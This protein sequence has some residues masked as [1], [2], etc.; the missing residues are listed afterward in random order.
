MQSAG[1]ILAGG[2]GTR[3]WPLSTEEKPKQFLELFGGESL[4][5]KSWGRLSR[6][7]SPETIFV[8]TQ[9]G[10]RQR[11][12]EQLPRLL[13]ENVLTEPSRRNTAPAIALA[14]ARINQKLPGATVAIVPSD[15]A[16]TNETS[17]SKA[18]STALRYAAGHKELV[19]IGIEPAEP[20]SGFGY[21][22]LGTAVDEDIYRV[23][24]YVEKPPREKA[25]AFVR[26]GNYLWN[27]GM[28]V[29]SLAAFQETLS[30]VAPAIL[31]L[32]TR[33]LDGGNEKELY[34]RMPLISIDFAVMEKAGS[35]VTVRAQNLG[36]SDVGTWSSVVRLTTSSSKGSLTLENAPGVL[37]IGESSRPVVVIGVENIAIVDSPHGLLVL[38]LDHS[39]ELSPVVKK[40]LRDKGNQ[41]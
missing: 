7:V 33:I 31:D 16:V 19:T 12:L 38:G 26:S 1:L 21:L 27:G 29:W 24:R 32:T 3:L 13:P 8:A 5:Q 20:N 40:L 35:V 6:I 36:W 15:H 37:V 14:C 25:E 39:E 23:V 41:D 10:Y 34:A 18:I 28:F 30:R 4:L 17:F 22:E 11:V 2:S 9:E